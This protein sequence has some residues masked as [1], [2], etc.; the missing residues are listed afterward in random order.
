[1]TSSLLHNT[2]TSVDEVRVVIAVTSQ[3]GFTWRSVLPIMVPG[4]PCI[5]TQQAGLEQQF[6]TSRAMSRVGST[7]KFKVLDVLT[8]LIVYNFRRCNLYRKRPP[9]DNFEPKITLRHIRSTILKT[10]NC[11]GQQVSGAMHILLQRLPTNFNESGCRD[12][13]IVV[14]SPSIPS[15]NPTNQRWWTR[16]WMLCF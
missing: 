15:K 10:M 12:F 4:I 11:F 14:S 6:R 3:P 1:M 16:E 2:C 5:R 13:T 9:D 8:C 7:F